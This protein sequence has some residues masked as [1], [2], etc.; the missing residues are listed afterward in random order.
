MF[1]EALDLKVE[2]QRREWRVK[3]IRKRQVVVQ[4]VKF[5]LSTLV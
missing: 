1:W 4:S 2:C 5:G 3:R